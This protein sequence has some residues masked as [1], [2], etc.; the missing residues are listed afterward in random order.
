M[1]IPECI[2]QRLYCSKLQTRALVSLW[3]DA[4][5]YQLTVVTIRDCIILMRN[6]VMA[7]YSHLK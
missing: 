6:K 2:Q 5:D 7:T 1:G 4:P 3:P